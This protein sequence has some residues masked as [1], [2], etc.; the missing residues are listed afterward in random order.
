MNI[1]QSIPRIDCQRFAK[2]GTKSLSHC[3]RYHGESEDCA[4]CT[5]II[6][7]PKAQVNTSSG[8]KLKQCTIC[9]RWMPLFRFY[10]RQIIRADK[11]YQSTTSECKMCK[12]AK[13]IKQRKLKNYETNSRT[14][15]RIRNR[16]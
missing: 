10:T 3:R 14:I 5:L 7:K 4:G 13:V 2:C 8:L 11:I 16:N 12:S 9:G 15:N 1:P 6:R